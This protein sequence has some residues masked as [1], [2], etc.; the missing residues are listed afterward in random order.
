MR[1]IEIPLV[2]P[3]VLDEDGSGRKA[4]HHVSGL[5]KHILL[6]M[7]PKR[8]GSDITDD[9]RVLWEMGLAWEDIALSRAFWRRILKR[10]FPKHSFR[11]VQ[12]EKDGIWGTTDML[13]LSGERPPDMVD[14]KGRVNTYDIIPRRL[15]TE[16]KLTQISMVNDPAESIK[17][18]SWRVQMMAYCHMWG[19]RDALLPVCF[20]NGDYRPRRIVPRAWSVKFEQSE[21]VENWGMLLQARDEILETQ[22]KRRVK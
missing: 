19:A 20:L 14:S 12:M 4:G 15:I 8:Y 6:K 13:S 7:D 22:P 5:I 2:L 18:W 9:T 11:Q 1:F 21:L 16:S 10:K 3:S 17:F